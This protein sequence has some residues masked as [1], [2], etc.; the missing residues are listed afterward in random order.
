MHEVEDRREVAKVSLLNR[1]IVRQAIAHEGFLL[2]V[3]K[4]PR[5]GFHF[6]QATERVAVRQ[7]AEAGAKESLGTPIRGPLLH[8]R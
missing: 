1:P 7:R 6:H 2:S 3:I 5:I 8:R 4:T